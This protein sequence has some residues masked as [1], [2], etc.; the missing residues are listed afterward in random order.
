MKLS[1]EPKIEDYRQFR[2]SPTSV[3]K[4]LIAVSLNFSWVRHYWQHMKRL[5]KACL[6]KTEF[7][8]NA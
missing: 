7:F 4:S 3:K 6:K 2:H 5:L 1:L 8:S